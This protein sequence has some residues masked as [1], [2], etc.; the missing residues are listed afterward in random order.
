MEQT[1]DEQDKQDEQG[2]QDEQDERV[3]YVCMEPCNV[4]S[5]CACKNRYIHTHC[6]IKLV[7]S[8]S[9]SNICSVCTQPIS[10]VNVT[11]LSFQ[12]RPTRLLVVVLIGLAGILT[13]LFVCVV[14]GVNY[15]KIPNAEIPFLILVVF[16]VLCVCVCTFWI[17]CRALERHEAGM[18]VWTY[19]QVISGKI[20]CVVHG[21]SEQP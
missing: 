15:N 11:N 13:E 12:R 5:R 1:A 16:S 17:R 7:E 20:L 8:N 19:R 10:N 2:E 21:D 9:L 4:L 18:P 3:C 6:L 14:I